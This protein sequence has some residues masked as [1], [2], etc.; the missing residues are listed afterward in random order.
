M[1]TNPPA[2]SGRDVP[3]VGTFVARHRRSPIMRKVAGVCRRYLAWHGDFSYD[4]RTNGE[5][6]VLER[7]SKFQP[8]VIFDVGANVGDWSITARELCPCAE[9]HA[10]EIA[11]S[12]FQTLVV[13]IGHLEKVRCRNSGLSDSA[14]S[15]RIRHYAGQPSLTT[16]TQYP[17]PFAFVEVEAEVVTGDSYAAASGIEHIDLLKID[18]E[19]MEERVLKGFQGMLER[20]AIDLIQFEY[21][22]VNIINRFLLR[23]FYAFFRERGY[24][25][26]KVF[27]NYIDFRDYDLA[28]ED[29]MGPNYVACRKDM[30]EYLHALG[31]DRR[32][33]ALGS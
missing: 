24:V 18:V 6:F 31:G 28:D 3:R 19:G 16:A 5:R 17:H 30:P 8:Q 23:D 7:L 14:G 29:F 26:G 20:R 12:T 13:N 2:A 25:V 4:L 11:P 10:F 21:G 22:R 15:I 33:P 27:P 9:I 1:A 32:H